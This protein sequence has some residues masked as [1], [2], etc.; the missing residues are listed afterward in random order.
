M[1]NWCEGVLKIRGKKSN[2]IRFAKE[3]ITG[4]NG[5]FGNNDNFAIK[6][7]E[8]R[9]TIKDVQD[10][11]VVN[12]HRMFIQDETICWYWQDYEDEDSLEQVS[13]SVQQAWDINIGDLVGLSKMY[14][15]DFRIYACEMGMEFNHEIEVK[16]G[17]LT[18]DRVLEFDDYFWECPNPHLGG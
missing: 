9:L 11:H 14:N 12:T 5:W 3:C 2:I 7:D 17:D 13:M 15:I 10:T 16:N 18:L 6:I 4:I 8:D 1:P